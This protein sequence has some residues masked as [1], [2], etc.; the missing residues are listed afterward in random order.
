MSSGTG[1]FD[2]LTEGRLCSAQPGREGY[3][4]VTQP[5]R[6]SDYLLSRLRNL[7]RGYVGVSGGSE[8]CRDG[9]GWAVGLRR[10]RGTR[11]RLGSPAGPV[12]PAA[13]RGQ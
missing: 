5:L 9:G 6:R 1:G 12:R 3:V 7:R 10:G 2:W 13:D 4:D 11:A 8:G